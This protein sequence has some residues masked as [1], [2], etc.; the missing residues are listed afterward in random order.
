MRIFTPRCAALFLAVFLATVNAHDSF[1]G[2]EIAITDG[3]EGVPK[4]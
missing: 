3:D 2:K 4:N 1:T